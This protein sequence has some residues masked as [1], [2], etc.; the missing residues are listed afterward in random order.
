MSW[1]YKV[2][3]LFELNDDHNVVRKDNYVMIDDWFKHPEDIHDLLLAMPKEIW[4]QAPGTRNWI[5]YY[6]T[7]PNINNSFPNLEKTKARHDLLASVIRNTYP[8][9]F[10]RGLNFSRSFTF[11][12]FKHIKTGRSKDF[13]HHPHKDHK[14]INCLVYLDKFESGG[15]AL[16]RDADWHVDREDT[17][18]IIDVSKYSMVEVIPAKFNRMVI[19]AG[20]LLHGAYIE[21]NSVYEKDWRIT[22]ASLVR[23]N[24]QQNGIRFV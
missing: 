18:L 23:A 1:P 10:N 4:K 6:D 13:Q 3:E 21:D 17:N 22:Y 24:E 16:Y 19:F 2:E 5:D 8:G 20:D 7:R 14:G 9:N 11:N 15:T 12:V